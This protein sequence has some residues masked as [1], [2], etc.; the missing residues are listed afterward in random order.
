MAHPV[1][2][3]P[4]ITHHADDRRT[5]LSAAMPLPPL[6]LLIDCDPGIDDALALLLAA[7]APGL[8]LRAVTCVAGNRPVEQTAPNARR[9]L[10]L[11]GADGVPVYAGCARPLAQPEPRSNLVHGADGLGG[12]ELP[13]RG[14]VQA[15][16]AVDVIIEALQSAPAGSLHLVALGP[17]TNLALAELRTP[18]LLKRAARIDI[19]GGAADRP[20]NV[21]PHAEFNFH[22]DPLAAQ[23]VL[24]AGAAVQ[25]F[26]LDVTSQTAMSEA[27][28]A[29][30]AALGTPVASAAHAMLQAYANVDPLLHDACPVAALIEPGLFG[31]EPR[32]MRVEWRD[33]VSEGRLVTEAPR[34]EPTA[35]DGWGRG[36]LITSVDN[37]RLL[38]LVRDSVAC[39]PRR[40]ASA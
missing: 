7:A 1:P 6:P 17:L 24:C 39:L 8:A 21:T 40:I 19:M 14:R 27:W 31:G 26:G 29:S 3:V 18:G 33:A 34:A 35:G 37:T 36:Q 5:T 16:H 20:G 15:R 4:K 25:V 23:I 12:V 13:L 11:A 30:I 38:A 22:C 28:R 10:D 32:R 2:R 9:I